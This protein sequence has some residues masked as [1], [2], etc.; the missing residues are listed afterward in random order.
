[1][2]VKDRMIIFAIV[3]TIIGFMIALQ[4]KTTN[5]PIVRDTRDILELRQDSRIEKERQQ[6]LNQEIEKQ[7]LLLN[8]LKGKDNLEDV[9][10]NAVNDLKKQAGLT[11]VS[12]EG[13]IIEI[14]SIHTDYG[15]IPKM[16]PPH[17]LWIL[18]NELNIY[19]AKEIAI[20]NQRIIS[21]SAIRDVNGV[22]HVNAKRIPELPL[23]VKV[24]ASDAE[25]LHHEMIVSQSIEYFAIEN[26]SLT[27]TPINFVVL[28]GYDESLRIRN[29]RPVKGES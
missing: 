5:E 6:E 16:V 1:M 25:K 20:G 22:T 23:K 10:V 7:L 9:M 26:L 8:Q 12:G 24:L 2:I 11:P 28:P 13:I 4:F 3:T 15:Y 27:S 18:I 14:N 21:T 29:L 19:N 17:L